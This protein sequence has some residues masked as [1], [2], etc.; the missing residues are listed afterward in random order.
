MGV[1]RNAPTTLP[2]IA[3]ETQNRN[4]Q[5]PNIQPTFNDNVQGIARRGVA[6]NAQNARN[7]LGLGLLKYYI[8]TAPQ[9]QD[10]T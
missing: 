2:V 3:H 7:T 1:A 5:N 9:E 6:C 8:S 10:C 4:A